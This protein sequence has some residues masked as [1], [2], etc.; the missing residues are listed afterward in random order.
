[1]VG[2]GEPLVGRLLMFDAQPT[3]FRELRLRRDEQCAT[4][5]KDA[6]AWQAWERGPVALPSPAS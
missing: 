2:Y 1:M 3:S 6:A 5:G 4:C